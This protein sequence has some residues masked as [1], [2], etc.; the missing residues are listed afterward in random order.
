MRQLI[1]FTRISSEGHPATQFLPSMSPPLFGSALSTPTSAVYFATTL[2]PQFS[3]PTTSFYTKPLIRT[4][5]M[6]S[7]S[8]TIT[9]GESYQDGFPVRVLNL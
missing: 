5:P 1:G 2:L 9:V 8:L 3:P 7:A 6:T 4:F